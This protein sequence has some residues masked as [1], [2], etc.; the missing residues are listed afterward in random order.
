MEGSM[1]RLTTDAR[2]DVQV[3]PADSTYVEGDPMQV[4]TVSCRSARAGH[5]DD[6]VVVMIVCSWWRH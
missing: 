5:R 3:I 6:V 1:A 2:C 4:D